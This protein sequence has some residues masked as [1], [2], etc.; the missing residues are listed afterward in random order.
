MSR[1]R[2]AKSFAKK[3]GWASRIDAG[4][5]DSEGTFL[6]QTGLNWHFAKYWQL[7]GHI[8]NMSVDFETGS[9][10]DSDFY[11]Y[12]VDETGGGLGIMVIW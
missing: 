11:L 8:K 9:Q 3:W 10:G 12:D 5:G 2:W 6:V 4:F 1:H 7:S